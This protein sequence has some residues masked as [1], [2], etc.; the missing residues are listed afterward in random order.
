MEKRIWISDQRF[1]RGWVIYLSVGSPKNLNMTCLPDCE[2]TSLTQVTAFSLL[3]FF[4]EQN[5]TRRAHSVTR[6]G[7]SDFFFQIYL[8]RNRHKAGISEEKNLLWRVLVG[9]PHLQSQWLKSMK[10]YA[11]FPPTRDLETPAPQN[12]NWRDL[13]KNFNRWRDGWHENCAHVRRGKR[14]TLAMIT[15]ELL[16]I[17]QTCGIERGIFSFTKEK[18]FNF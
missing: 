16:Y 18:W 10:R 5:G 9:Q 12:E 6:V 15:L 2:R 4:E 7:K 13:P 17:L 1:G 14:G 3:L 11:L 8:K